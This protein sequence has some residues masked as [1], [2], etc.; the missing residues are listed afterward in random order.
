MKSTKKNFPSFQ[1]IRSQSCIRYW[2]VG[3]W[4][5]LSSLLDGLTSVLYLFSGSQPFSM[6]WQRVRPQQKISPSA[7]L[8]QMKAEC[9]FQMNAM[10]SS[11]NS[12]NQPG[13]GSRRSRL[14]HTSDLQRLMVPLLQ[15]WKKHIT[16]LLTCS[17]Q[18]CISCMIVAILQG[19]VV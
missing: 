11:A 15:P 14:I 13:M 12:T 6:C 5:I 19:F 3:G 9:P 1:K 17:H 16:M 7:P 18:F 4:I 10:I 8:T 2:S